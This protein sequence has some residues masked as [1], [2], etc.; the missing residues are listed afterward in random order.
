[1]IYLLLDRRDFQESSG[2]FS[3]TRPAP[4]RVFTAAR[5]RMSVCSMLLT[6]GILAILV[7]ASMAA[8]GSQHTL[9]GYHV[10]WPT[11]GFSHLIS[12]GLDLENSTYATKAMQ[13]MGYVLLSWALL[14][15][16][17]P[18]LAYGAWMVLAT[19]L[20]TANGGDFAGEVFP[21]LTILFMV[22]LPAAFAVVATVKFGFGVFRRELLSIRA[23]AITAACSVVTALAVI[24]FNRLSSQSSP[25]GNLHIALDWL[26]ILSLMACLPA[27]AVFSQATWVNRLR[28][29]R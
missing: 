24:L 21:P 19:L 2:I 6:L 4:S 12:P 26:S 15:L 27:L 16:P 29:H 9:E 14:W 3:K 13:V 17:I 20:I 23:I 18:A 5:L 1:L 11:V 7:L 22:W 8:L 28:Y 10:S 25:L